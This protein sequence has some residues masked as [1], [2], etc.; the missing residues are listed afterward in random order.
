[1]CD[2]PGNGKTH[3]LCCTTNQNHTSKE[4]LTKNV[5]HRAN[6]QQTVNAAIKDAKMEFKMMMHKERNHMERA[7]PAIIEPDFFHQM[8]FG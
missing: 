1:M 7:Q 3:G 4:F 8:V 2:L 6:S 5:K